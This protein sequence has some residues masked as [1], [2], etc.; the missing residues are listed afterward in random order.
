MNFYE[1]VPFSE[2]EEQGQVLPGEKG[3]FSSFQS[4]PKECLYV[5]K[6]CLYICK[7]QQL[8]S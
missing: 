3:I 2:Q 5:C 7:E 8:M 6:E 1:Q 4:L